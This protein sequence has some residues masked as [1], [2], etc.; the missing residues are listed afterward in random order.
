MFDIA[1]DTIKITRGDACIITVSA[2]DKNNQPYQFKINDIIRIGVYEKGNYDKA[3]LI[4]DTNI[5][6]ESEQVDIILNQND[7]KIGEIINKT[8]N[9]WY[10]IQ[11][12]PETDP[13]TIIGHD[14][15]GPKIF[16]LFP[17]GAD[18]RND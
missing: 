18:I 1:G 3:V 5:T 8:V 13:H 15:D 7:T 11:L 9:Y 14:D 6:E 2:E 17:E 4:K 10:E 12:N 16:R